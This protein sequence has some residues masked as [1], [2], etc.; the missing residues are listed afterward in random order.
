MTAARLVACVQVTALVAAS[1]SA[2]TSRATVT[3]LSD[4]VLRGARGEPLALRPLVQQ[5]RFTAVIFFS[6]GCPCAAA[7]RTRLAQLIH[8]MQ[9]RDVG[10]VIVDSERHA[11]G[12]PTPAFVANTDLPLFADDGGRLARRL[13]AQFAT[14]TFVFDAAGTLRYR[15]GIDDDRRSLRPRPTAHLRDEL[16]SLLAGTAPPYVTTKALGCALRLR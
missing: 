1:A 12:E 14:E 2:S 3:D 13:D 5:H 9:P 16:Q 11:A 6:S 15:G 10:F 8:D 7:H 4:V